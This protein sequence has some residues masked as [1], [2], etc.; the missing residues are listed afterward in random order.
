MKLVFQKFEASLPLR[1]DA[2]NALR[3]EEPSLYSRCAL[4][5]AQGFP[6]D[7]LEPAFFFADDGTEVKA[8]KV[9]Y[10]AGDPLLLDLNDRRILSQA[11]KLLSER[12]AFDTSVLQMLEK[13]NYEIEAL[14]EE[15]C[16]QMSADYLFSDE[17]DTSKYL[18]MLG[19]G[20]DDAADSTVFQKTTHFLRL[21]SDLFPDKVIAFVNLPVYLTEM[22]YNE[23]CEL[24]ASLQLCV[25]SYERGVRASAGHLENI[26][27]IDENYLEIQ[28]SCPDDRPLQQ[29]ICPI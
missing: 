5:L 10:F 28:S 26:L 29:G 9:M 18:K 23:I 8:S 15:Q 13:M 20:V 22:Q 27:Y 24:A 11:I 25:L 19:F 17:W 12:M 3:I 1:C 7:A 16:L 21:M 6:S 14:F 2:L 4:S